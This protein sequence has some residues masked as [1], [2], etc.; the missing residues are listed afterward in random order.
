[1]RSRKVVLAVVISLALIS[2][3]L[4]GGAVALVALD[5]Q[6]PGALWS[7]AGVA[8]GAL[9]AMLTSTTSSIPASEIVA[10]PEIS[11]LS[12]SDFNTPK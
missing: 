7:L 12:A 1:M 8:V 6:V 4:A 9:A 5:K 2:L 11:S 3:V 10:P